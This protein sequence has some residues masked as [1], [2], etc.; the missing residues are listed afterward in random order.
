MQLF[1]ITKAFKGNALYD[2]HERLMKTKNREK[3]R[4]REEPNYR[5]QTEIICLQRKIII[6]RAEIR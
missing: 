1:K 5:S 4:D 3:D 2:I 6:V